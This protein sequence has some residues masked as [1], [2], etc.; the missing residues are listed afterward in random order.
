MVARMMMMT[1]DNE[2]EDMTTAGQ[3]ICLIDICLRHL[4]DV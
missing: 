2:E 4:S 1:N 3:V